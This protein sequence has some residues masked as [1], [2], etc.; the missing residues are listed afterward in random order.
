M[1]WW[2]G[3]ESTMVQITLLEISEI[4][5]LTIITDTTVGFQTLGYALRN[6]LHLFERRSVLFM[7]NFGLIE[8]K[9]E[10]EISTEFSF[11][12]S[13]SKR[14]AAVVESSAVA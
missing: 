12:T 6:G 7:N 8:R 10:R 13:S 14:T 11:S 2:R 4:T 9:R 5:K 3:E 1:Y